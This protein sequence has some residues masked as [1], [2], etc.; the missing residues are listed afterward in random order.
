MARDARRSVGADL[1]ADRKV[2]PHVQEG[3]LAAA[4]G[5]E[6]RSQRRLAR[7]KPADVFRVLGDDRRELA[8][9]RFQRFTCAELVPGV[10]VATTH[11]FAPLA[12]EDGHQP[13]AALR[14]MLPTL[15]FFLATG[16]GLVLCLYSHRSRIRQ[17]GQ[18]GARAVHT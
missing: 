18:A 1:F 14:T 11:L 13:R 6:L 7:L 10:E 4:L 5:G 2:Q 3:I 17:V 16:F 12:C 9:E 15:R 8:L